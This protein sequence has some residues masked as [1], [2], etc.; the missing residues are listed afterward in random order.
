[1]AILPD[2]PPP[3]TSM[4]S[5]EEVEEVAEDEPPPSPQEAMAETIEDA[6]EESENSGYEDWETCKHFVI[7]I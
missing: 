1:M 4:P 3:M 6:E 5:P 7:L 2:E